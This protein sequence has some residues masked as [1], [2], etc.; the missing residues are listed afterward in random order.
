MA[1]LPLP[2]DNIFADAYP[3]L[4]D[5]APPYISRD[6]VPVKCRYCGTTVDKHELRSHLLRLQGTCQ[7]QHPL[8]LHRYLSLLQEASGDFPNTFA[9]SE[10]EEDDEEVSDKLA[11]PVIGSTFTAWTDLET[12]K[13]FYALQRFSKFRCDAIAEH[14]GTKNEVEVAEI[15]DKFEEA[16]TLLKAHNAFNNVS[17]PP[18]ARQMSEAWLRMEEALAED[19]TI[20]EEF[21]ERTRRTP[22]EFRD[23]AQH[24]IADHHMHLHCTTCRRHRC[25]GKQPS[26][27]RC[28]REG[29]ACQWPGPIESAPEQPEQASM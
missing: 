5:D 15:V 19:V 9:D 8:Q 17:S 6:A 20:W 10:G 29:L 13:F 21:V 24:S 23:V 27:G 22:V 12:E 7:L 11:R 14:I 25:D 1:E 4:P 16:T 3:A 18:A 2:P 28:L 26:C